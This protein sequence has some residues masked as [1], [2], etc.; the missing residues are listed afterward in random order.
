MK[1]Y[2]M[3]PLNDKLILDVGTGGGFF[4]RSLLKYGIHSSRLF[5]IDFWEARVQE[6]H[7]IAPCIPLICGTAEM[8]PFPNN[9]FDV[10]VQRTMFSSILD[11]EKRLKAAREMLRVV[12]PGGIVVS[13][14]FRIKRPGDHDVCSITAAELHRLFGDAELTLLSDGMPPQLERMLAPRSFL[15]CQFLSTIWPSPFR[16]FYW[17]IVRKERDQLKP[18]PSEHI[19]RPSQILMIVHFLMSSYESNVCSLGE[20]ERAAIAGCPLRVRM[21][22]HPRPSCRSGAKLVGPISGPVPNGRGAP[23]SPSFGCPGCSAGVNG[24]AS[25]LQMVIAATIWLIIYEQRISV[26]RSCIN[27]S[28][29]QHESSFI[30]PD[31]IVDVFVVGSS[32]A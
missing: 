25:R 29:L 13:H 6:G 4:L 20:S 9:C 32:Q 12:K 26:D 15:A 21:G 5:G 24:T 7:A 10:A 8:L 3:F 19:H 16:C 14:D 31:Q 1:R 2:S 17:A 11:D 27:E 22:L 28:I 30:V 23:S 18:R